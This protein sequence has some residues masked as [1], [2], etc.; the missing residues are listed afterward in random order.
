MQLSKVL[1][2]I[3]KGMDAKVMFVLYG[4]QQLCSNLILWSLAGKVGPPLFMN[5]WEELIAG[6][7]CG[8]LEL[9]CF[10]AMS[11]MELCGSCCY[12]LAPSSRRSGKLFSC[13]EV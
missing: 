4:G 7:G 11:E 9:Q 2:G 8:T 3:K 10:C 1:Q 5:V 13:T 6:A 12:E